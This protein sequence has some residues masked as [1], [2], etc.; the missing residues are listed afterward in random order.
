MGRVRRARFCSPEKMG[1]A[2]FFEAG[3]GND[4][5]EKYIREDIVNRPLDE[6]A[7]KGCFL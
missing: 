1:V 3:I 4:E 6:K 5:I 2:Q 7:F